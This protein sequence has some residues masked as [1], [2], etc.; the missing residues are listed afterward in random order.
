MCILKY[1]S[2]LSTFPHRDDL[3]TARLLDRE[4]IPEHNVTVRVVDPQGNVSYFSAI[5]AIAFH[6]FFV[7][8]DWDFFPISIQDNLC[9]KIW[10]FLKYDCSWV[11]LLAKVALIIGSWAIFLGI[12]VFFNND[13]GIFIS[14][15]NQ[16]FSKNL[17]VSIGIRACSFVVIIHYKEREWNEVD[18]C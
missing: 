4:D 9:M 10:D 17:L 14:L 11:I 6:W 18:I 2:L 16:N 1:Q 7:T 8:L 15:T 12:N 13:T 5:S 3:Q